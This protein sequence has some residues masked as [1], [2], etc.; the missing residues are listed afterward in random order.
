MKDTSI[1]IL[2]DITVYMKYARY[3]PEL[4]RR[5]TWEEICYRNSAMHCKKYPALS[6]EIK[7]AYKDFVIPK[8]VLP[9]MR[10]LQ[11]AR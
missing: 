10:S 6:N 3:Q 4:K 1:Q 9:S 5:E 7:Q 8:K 11:F 2:S